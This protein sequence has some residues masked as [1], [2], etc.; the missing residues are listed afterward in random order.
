MRKLQPVN[1]AVKTFTIGTKYALDRVALLDAI[2]IRRGV[3]R[4]RVIADTLDEA[5]EREF[6][7]A[8]KEERLDAA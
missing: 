6:P 8:L 1:G 5:I 4:S 2:A 3:S 7:G